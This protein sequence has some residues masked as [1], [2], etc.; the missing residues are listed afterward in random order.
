MKTLVEKTWIIFLTAA[1]FCACSPSGKKS[2]EVLVQNTVAD[3][4]VI[5][6]PAWAFGLVYGA[7]TNQEQ[8]IELINKIIEHDYPI[9]AFWI[10]SWFWD[11]QNQGQ[12]PKKYMD[13]VADTISYP[14][15]QGMWDYMQEQNI[16]AGIWMWDAIMQTGNEAEYEDFKSKGFFKAEKIRTDGW[17]NGLR[18]TIIGDNS[19]EVRG[20]WCGDIDFTNPEAT[21]Y[22]QQKVKH[23]FDKGADFIKLDKT[24]AIPVCKA[25]FETTQKLG[26]ESRGRG[27]ILS[28]SH[29]VETDEF[30]RYP[31]KWT[32]DTRSDW[33]VEDPKHEFSPWLPRVAFKENLA[34]YTDTSR[35][36]HQIP[37]LSNDLGG[38]AVGLNGQIDEELY[39]RWVEFAHFVPLTT[40]FSQP[41]NP[42]GNIA[43]NIS[44]RADSVFRFYSH[45][46]MQLFPYIYSYAHLA[47]LEGV[48]IIRPTRLYEYLFGNEILVA[49]VY[50]Q[51]ARTREVYL[52]AGAQ[53]TH[54]WTRETFE[55]GQTVV[56]KAPPGQIPLFVKQGAIVPKRAY[57]RSIEAGTNDWL[58]LDI[59]TG[60]NGTFRL[61]EDDG[62]SNDYLEGMLA[63]TTLSYTESDKKATLTIHPVEGSFSG[64]NQLRSWRIVLHGA[65]NVNRIQYKGKS[66]DF[67]VCSSSVQFELPEQD[68][69]ETIEINISKDR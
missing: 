15:M 24:D 20:T 21:A 45:L 42:S 17:H 65:G 69:H 34:M 35:H 12:G 23:F 55:G 11:W 49:P 63:Q 64:M 40:P 58:E 4:N 28:H 43:F 22:F 36:F 31:G 3:T 53:W 37:F 2:P 51:G 13:F 44:E 67:T 27:F 33:T 5:L 39:I 41:E 47:R 60:D 9:D 29:G 48:N 46:K 54:Y 8:S 1:V 56:V 52:P 38:F 19:R 30:K 66:I 7:Y 14:D 59:F 6:P 16:K 26:K 68:K 18:T 62:A 10:D 50:E 57:A 25:M 32:D 61:V